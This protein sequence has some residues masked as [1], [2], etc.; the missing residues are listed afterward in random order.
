[1]D[2]KISARGSG[3]AGGRDAEG[4]D[5][6]LEGAHGRG[7]GEASDGGEHGAGE[8]AASREACAGH[9]GSWDGGRAEG[10]GSGRE[11]AEGAG[12]E[13]GRGGSV[14]V[15]GG[16]TGAPGGGEGRADETQAGQEGG[17]EG[18]A[19][20]GRGSGMGGGKT[21]GGHAQGRGEAARS[22]GG[23]GVRGLAGGGGKDEIPAVGSRGDR[24]PA[25]SGDVSRE[26]AE[27][28]AIPERTAEEDGDGEVREGAG[29]EEGGRE[30]VEAVGRG[31]SETAGTAGDSARGSGAAGGRDAE[32]GD[33]GL[34]GAHG[35]GE[36]EASD[37][38]EHGAGERAASREA[39]A[40]HVGSW[41]GGR[42]EGGGSGRESAEGA[43]AEGGRGGG[44]GVGG[45][46]TGAPGGGEGRA[47]ETQAGQEGGEEGTARVG[48]GSGMG[49][50]KTG[51]GHAQGRGEAAR[52]G[53]GE[54][55]R[56][57]AG[58][59]GKDEIPAVGSRG[60]REPAW[61]G[62][63][64]R[65]LAEARAIPERTAEEDGDGERHMVKVCF[66]L[67][68]FQLANVEEKDGPESGP[69]HSR[70]TRS[71]LE[72]IRPAGENLSGHHNP[73]VFQDIDG[74]FTSIVGIAEEYLAKI[75]FLWRIMCSEHLSIKFSVHSNMC[76]VRN[77]L[78]EILGSLEQEISIFHLQAVESWYTNDSRSVELENLAF[79]TRFLRQKAKEQERELRKL[80]DIQQTNITLK[81]SNLLLNQHVQDMRTALSEANNE[82]E[83][84]SSSMSRARASKQADASAEKQSGEQS[85]T[86]QG[87]LLDL[88]RNAGFDTRREGIDR[89]LMH[90]S[91]MVADPNFL[92]EAMNG[93]MDSVQDGANHL[94]QSSPYQP[95]KNKS[96]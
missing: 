75:E 22:G 27:A 38:G 4:G 49:G 59:G 80:A 31:G 67:W 94:L 77:E 42:A 35:R 93:L 70:H 61:S 82:L 6:G 24:E 2:A 62:D 57:L 18:T 69:L 44:V 17:E 72:M 64:S 89:P 11:S 20:V 56:G 78:V 88:R 71:S 37:G 41:D 74:K 19:R 16:R 91:K 73:S 83:L 39:C 7:E 48:R 90:F 46:R 33:M 5:M 51:G 23:E 68:G 53:G 15:G 3:A 8:R 55:V 96:H 58:G 21:G 52:S 9:V 95:P 79:E 84:L 65:E 87:S 29:E 28:R 10:G 76:S 86:L 81:K 34:E 32:G 43:G 14:G 47:D 1:M 12:A 66:L 36:G 54:G 25:W 45:G 13:G 60:D 92:G 40:G 26:L 50:G 63:V 85:H 30:G